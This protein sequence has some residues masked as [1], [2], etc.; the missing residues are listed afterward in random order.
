MKPPSIA[1]KAT[2]SNNSKDTNTGAWVLQV[3][4]FTSEQNAISM[5]DRLKLKRFK[6]YKSSFDLDNKTVYRVFVGPF[7]FKDKAS[8]VL[9]KVELESKTKVLLKVYNPVQH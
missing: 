8:K 1:L 9:T 4:S 3:A 2:P 6:S 5:V 7:V